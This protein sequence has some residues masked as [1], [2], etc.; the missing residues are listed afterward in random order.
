MRTT[1]PNQ[2]ADKPT[3]LMVRLDV[4]S[5]AVLARAAELRGTSISDF[6]RMVT[7]SQARR[8]VAAAEEQ[9][10]AMTAEE[11]LAFCGVEPAG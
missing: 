3:T 1:R 5:K 6:V 10:I 11:Q 9:L 7:V 4:D 2:S 8:E